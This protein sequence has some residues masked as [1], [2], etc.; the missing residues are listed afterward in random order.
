MYVLTMVDFFKASENGEK[1][2]K[3]S[4]EANERTHCGIMGVENSG[5]HR[6]TSQ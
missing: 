2:D 1:N 5:K 6:L 4:D 3:T